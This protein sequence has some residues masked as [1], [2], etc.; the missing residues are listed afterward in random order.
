MT[1]SIAHRWSALA[2]AAVVGLA[3]VESVTAAA[4]YRDRIEPEDWRALRQTLDTVEPLPVFLATPWLGPRARMELPA[5][6][7]LEVAAGRDLR[8]RRDFYTLGL[9]GQT[10]SEHLERD[11]EGLPRP[12]M[13]DARAIGPFTLAR[14]RAPEAAVRRW[15]LLEARDLR[16]EVDDSPC[17]KRARGWQC[18]EGK[19]TVDV[20][21]IDFRP[22]RCLSVDVPDGT[23]VRLVAPDVPLGD[24]L[25]GHVGFHDFNGRLRSD[26]P[27]R[28]SV[29]VDGEPVLDFVA[30]DEQGWL[31]FSAP[32]TPG[33]G[34]VTV[35]ILV[36]ARGTWDRPGYRPG[37]PRPVC[38]ELRALE[39]GS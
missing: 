17:R 30:T 7:D 11:L 27:A 37:H 5:L 13:T 25:W 20:V 18:G 2:L 38:V 6:A 24:A 26:A 28:L 3:V 31:G 35:E 15:D 34:A 4:V 10:W 29:A 9:F 23:R 8:D 22:R 21:E 1:G 19:A 14:Y 16:V 12:E 33:R 39:A 36:T 32:T